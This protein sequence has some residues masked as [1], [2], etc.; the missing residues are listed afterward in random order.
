M[1]HLQTY[2]YVVVPSCIPVNVLWFY[3]FHPTP[4]TLYLQHPNPIFQVFQAFPE[5]NGS[6]PAPLYRLLDPNSPV[7]LPAPGSVHLTASDNRE[8]DKLVAALGRNKATWRRAILLHEWLLEIGHKADDRLL[9]TLI[10][11]CAQHGQITTALELYDWM[12][13]SPAEGGAGLKCTVYTYTAAM[14]AA[15]AGN[16][17]DKALQVRQDSQ[18]SSSFFKFIF[19]R[20]IILFKTQ[21]S[22]N[23]PKNP[24]QSKP[25]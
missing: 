8:L 24:K 23:K 6:L 18:F 21:P 14:R 17:I 4:H 25:N 20:W 11:V 15:L 12:R 16:A 10:R 9:T 19:F 3:S 22:G 5:A 2:R 1:V 7:D 13:A